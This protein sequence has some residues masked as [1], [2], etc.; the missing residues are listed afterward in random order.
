M[1]KDSALRAFWQGDKLVGLEIHQETASQPAPT[2]FEEEIVRI[3]NEHAELQTA[4]KDLLADL[5]AECRVSQN[6][7]AG[8]KKLQDEN[9]RLREAL[10]GVKALTHYH[11]SEDE[12]AEF[13]EQ[14]L[15]GEKGDSK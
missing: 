15:S 14:A 9:K 4:N 13:I 7:L 11:Y 10:E 2:P 3:F 6:L 1:D 12:I 8:Q 5:D